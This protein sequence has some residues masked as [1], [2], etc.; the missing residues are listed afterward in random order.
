MERTNYQKLT[1]ISGRV[2]VQTP[3]TTSDLI[4]LS[5]ELPC[6]L[7]YPILIAIY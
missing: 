1:H 6:E 4:I 3:I 7:I 2:G 5:V